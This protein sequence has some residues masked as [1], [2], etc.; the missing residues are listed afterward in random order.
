MRPALLAAALLVLAPTPVLAAPDSEPPRK[1]APEPAA[2]SNAEAVTVTFQLNDA[3]VKD[4]ALPGVRVGARRADVA[5]YQATGQSGADGKVQLSLPPGKYLVTYLKEGYIPVRDSAALVTRQGQVITTTLSMMLEAAGQGGKRRVQIVLNWGN[6]NEQVKDADAH[7]A[8]QD[9]KPRL[10]VYWKRKL[11]PGT[12][13][14]AELD[15]DDTDW[16]GPETVTLLDPPQGQYTYWVHNYSGEPALLG[17]SQVKVRV[18]FGDHVAGEFAVPETVY[19]RYWRPF[20]VLSVD[21]MLEPRLVPFSKEELASGL[22]RAEMEVADEVEPS[23]LDG[24]DNIA[25]D[26]GCDGDQLEDYAGLGV[27]IIVGLVL[28]LR[29]L[30]KR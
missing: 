30:S 12:E 6:E 21:A 19:S 25:S 1:N 17:A 14:S 24:D 15:V 16:G 13:V 26:G 2:P 23:R 27:L 20:K 22:D 18:L 7:L 28:F 29:R 4:K 11:H 3:M 9:L 10:H 8:R 5:T